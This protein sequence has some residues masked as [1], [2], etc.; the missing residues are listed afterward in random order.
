MDTLERLV[1]LLGGFIRLTKTT[2]EILATSSDSVEAD[3]SPALGAIRLGT[4]L[5]HPEAT[6]V[7]LSDAV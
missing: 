3:G 5:S 2:L 7:E 4:H 6:P 1:Y